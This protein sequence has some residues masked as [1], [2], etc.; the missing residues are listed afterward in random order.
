[1]SEGQIN[2]R[3]GCSLSIG[4]KDRELQLHLIS[5]LSDYSCSRSQQGL[6]E[7]SSFRMSGAVNLSRQQTAFKGANAECCRVCGNTSPSNLPL[8]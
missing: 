6:L 4:A 8:P 5:M 7:P 3:L 2:K 1:M